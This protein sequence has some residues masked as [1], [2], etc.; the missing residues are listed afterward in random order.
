MSDLPQEREDQLGFDLGDA[1]ASG[2][3]QPNLIEIREDLHAIL[4]AARRVTTD[5]IWDE[6]T[7]RYNKVIFVQMARWLPEEEAAQLCFEFMRELERIEAL[8]AA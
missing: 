7:Y 8:L 2:A 1:P 5:A 3:Y 4:E 6:R